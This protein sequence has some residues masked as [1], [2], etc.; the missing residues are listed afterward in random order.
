MET[1]HIRLDGTVPIVVREPFRRVNQALLALLRGFE[2]V[3][4]RRPTVHADRSVKDLTA[5]LLQ[6]SLMRVSALRDGYRP[7]MPPISGIADLTTWIQDTNRKFMTGTRFLSPQMLIELLERWDDEMLRAL[8]ALD[9]D[10]PGLGVA[11]AGEM[12]SPNW[13]DLA[14]EYTEKWHHQQQ[15]RDATGRPPLY[16]PALLA[17]VL[18][19]FARGLPFAYRDTMARDGTRVVVQV[20][21]AVRAEWTLRRDEGA[22]SLWRGGDAAPRASI[23]L[24]ADAAWRIWTKG[25]EPARA[26]ER[27]TIGGDPSLA[28]PLTRFVAIMA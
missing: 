1:R 12:E 6:T 10:A 18:E 11:W 5:H 23:S 21:G 4:W 24:E 9:P 13:F 14:R 19:T 2:P 20:T 17:P 8:A 28:E 22:W 27:L 25:I 7:P 15:L 3:D 26:L 16:E